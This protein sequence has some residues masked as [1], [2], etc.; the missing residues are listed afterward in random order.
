MLFRSFNP[1]GPNWSIQGNT[2]VFQPVPEADKDYTVVFIPSG[3]IMCQYDSSGTAS[4]NS[5]GT[6]TMATTPTLGSMDKRPNSYQGAYLRVLGTN[7]VDELVITDHD[8][9]YKVLTPSTD[10]QNS[11]AAGYTYEIV[12]F[13]MEPMIDAVAV[14][15]AIRAGVGRKI[16]QAHMQALMLAYKQAIKTAYDKIGR[17][18]V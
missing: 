7:L 16:T 2:I 5:N 4:I 6:F 14:S 10:F 13:L 15:A 1:N 8:A 11:V 9:I 17:A 3:D 18:H 12:P